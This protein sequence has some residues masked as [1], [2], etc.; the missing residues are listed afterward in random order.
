MTT[1]LYAALLTLWLVL[2]SM[3][4][5]ALRGNPMFA[6]LTLVDSQETMLDRAIRA[7]GNLTDNAPLLL[8]LLYLLATLGQS[9]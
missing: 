8:I 9:A 1:A 3:R 5:I 7:Q 2:L 6:F 4:V